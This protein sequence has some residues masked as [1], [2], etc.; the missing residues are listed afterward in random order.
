M[1]AWVLSKNFVS[2]AFSCW[3]KTSCPCLCIILS[4]PFSILNGYWLLDVEECACLVLFALDFWWQ[5]NY[6][7]GMLSTSMIHW[8]KIIIPFLISDINEENLKNCTQLY[9]ICLQLQS[10]NIKE[11][12]FSCSDHTNK[13]VWLYNIRK[14]FIHD[15]HESIEMTKQFHSLFFVNFYR[16]K[17]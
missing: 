10:L 3:S 7:R 6:D 2:L 17:K 15:I 4:I 13:S 12:H 14:L 5:K 16:N 8:S 9:L 11:A 1:V